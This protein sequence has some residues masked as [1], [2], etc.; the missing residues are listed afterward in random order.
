MRKARPRQRRLGRRNR[1]FRRRVA[2]CARF[3][4]ALSLACTEPLLAFQ[5]PLSEEAVRE[6]YF[7]GQRHDE[8]VTRALENYS[9]YFPVPDYGPQ[10]A[11]LTYLTPFA[12]AILASSNHIGNYSAQQAQIAHRGLRETVEIQVSIRFTDSYPAFVPSVRPNS[13]GSQPTLVPRSSDFWRD[14]EVTAF[15]GDRPLEPSSQDG[16]PDY[17]C[18]RYSCFLIGATIL[19]DFPADAF[20]KQDVTVQVDPPEGDRFAAGLDLSNLR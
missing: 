5:S 3:F 14:F 1:I 6:A 4:L 18:S 12:Q 10:I 15:D 19:L 20:Q 11:S 7:L 17:T 13:R 8:S 2:R 16:R 9:Q